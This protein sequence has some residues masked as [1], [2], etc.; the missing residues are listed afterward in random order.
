MNIRS[1]TFSRYLSKM[2][3]IFDR[4]EHSVTMLH[5]STFVF[6]GGV[7]DWFTTRSKTHWIQHSILHWLKNIYFLAN[8]NHFLRLLYFFFISSHWISFSSNFFFYKETMFH[9]LTKVIGQPQT[10]NKAKTRYKHWAVTW[11]HACK[12]GGSHF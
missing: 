3:R 8:I 9:H 2:M 7:V 1:L 5:K 11:G 10:E 4:A 12:R 6:L